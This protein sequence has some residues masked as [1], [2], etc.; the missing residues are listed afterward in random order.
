MGSRIIQVCR[1]RAGRNNIKI[2]M[3]KIQNKS[4]LVIPLS[5]LVIDISVI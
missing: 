4:G 3:F 1:A 5:V 2:Q